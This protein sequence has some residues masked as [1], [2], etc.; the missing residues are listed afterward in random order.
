M[1]RS[2]AVTALAL[3]TGA[4][5]MLS[6]CGS[7]GSSGNGGDAGQQNAKPG[8]VGGADEKYNRPKV[9]DIGEISL[10]VEEGF[11]NYNNYI[12][13]TNNF[14]ST[15]ALSQVLPSPF[16]TDL[17][18]GKLVIKVDGDL[19]DS[20]TVTSKDPQVIEWKVRKDAVWSDGQPIDCKDFYLKYLAATSKATTKG[21]DGSEASL[22]DSS[23]TGYDQMQSL[24]CA[25]N[26]KTVKTTFKK[27]FADYRALFSSPGNDNLL[28]AHILEQKTN[29]PD[30][31]KITPDQTDDTVKK[32]AE[33]YT[34]GWLGFD[35][36]VALSGGPYKI[37]SSDVQ[38]LTVLVRND[39]WWAEKGAAAK[40]IIKT[41]TDSQTALQQLQNKEV[42]AIAPQADG[43]VAQQARA[44]SNFQVFAAGGQTYEHI[45]FNMSRPLFK[46]HKEV[47]QA[48]AACVDRQSLIDNLVKDVDPN[49]KPLGSFMFV[50]NEVGYEDHYAD[51]ANGDVAAS[52]KL[53]EDA[54]WK[55]GPDGIYAK[56]GV[57]ASFKLG[58]K[59][60]QRR[61]DT[62]RL[63]QASCKQA[64]IEVLDDQTADFNDKRL[65]A[66]E[67]DAALFAW[68][69][70]PVKSA[71]FGNYVSKDKGGSSNY[72]FYTNSKVDELY[73]SSNNELDYEKR[74]GEL[75]ELDKLMREDLHSIPLFQLPDFAA[76]TSN[77]GPVSYVG[78]GGGITWNV[79]TW[80]KK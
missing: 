71:A 21:E 40:V 38:D 28:P 20:I 10:A 33:F 53:M 17:V 26:N 2:K 61:S 52:K 14:S 72:N 57:R 56:N 58:H 13:A 36:S 55:P 46:D 73:A 51:T 6:A 30:I 54:G 32:A 75:N 80:Q 34:K 74:V 50:P 64:G 60:V 39:K 7:G 31:T 68:V 37:E 22:W 27:P 23:P 59:I 66:S 67:F 11:H 12:G 1:R 47:R 19:M 15:I 18:N 76:A 79:N 8:E 24:E 78:V 48:I 70:T 77:I 45:D 9:D 41:A 63:V 43:A 65:P 3:I 16:Y 42:V 62:V 5:L 4:T 69:G 44:D 29:I 35:A 25:D 49:A